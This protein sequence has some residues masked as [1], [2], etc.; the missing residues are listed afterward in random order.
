MATASARRLA[1]FYFASGTLVLLGLAWVYWT[2]KLGLDYW[3]PASGNRVIASV[4]L[5][6]GAGTTHLLCRLLPE[7]RAG[8]YAGTDRR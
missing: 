5:I 2:G 4:A 3:L 6:A 1:A 8:G 7:D